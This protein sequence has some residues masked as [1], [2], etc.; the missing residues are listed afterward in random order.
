MLV[1]RCKFR[2]VIAKAPLGKPLR[3]DLSGSTPIEGPESLSVY[4]DSCDDKFYYFQDNP[5]SFL[6]VNLGQVKEATFEFVTEPIS[7]FPCLI[8]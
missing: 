2:L 7:G 6:R 1:F 4:G 5:D 3:I 8:I